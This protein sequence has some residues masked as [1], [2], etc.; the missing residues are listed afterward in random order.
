M[1]SSSGDALSLYLFTLFIEIL[2]LIL[3]R[4]NSEEFIFHHHCSNLNIINLCFAADLYLFA[5]GDVNSA[6]VIMEVLDEFKITSGLVPSLS[7]STTYFCNVLNQ[8]KLAILSVL[9]FEEGDM[10]C[11]KAKV[12]WDAI[13]LPK[14]EGGLGFHMSDTVSDVLVN[15]TWKWPIEWAVK[16][17]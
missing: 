1:G 15:D 7:K 4:Q 3:Q 14:N 8:T 10:R 5:H 2:T 16:Y 12:S 9:P 11:G 17:P 6:R 13:C